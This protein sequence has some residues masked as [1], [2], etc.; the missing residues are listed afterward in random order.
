MATPKKTTAAAPAPAPKKSAL[1]V[2]LQPRWATALL[3]AVSIVLYA[4][5]FRHGYALDDSIVITENMFTQQGVKGWPGIFGKD[6]FFGYFKVEGKDR[7]VSGGRYRPLSLALFALEYQI[8]GNSPGAMHVANVLWYALTVAMCYYVFLL[9]FGAGE[10]ALRPSSAK[11]HYWALGAALIFAVHPLHT[12]AVANIKGRDEILSLLGSM[13]AL[14]LVLRA[15]VGRQPALLAGAFAA[16][17]LGLLSKENAITFLAVAPLALWLFAR[18]GVRQAIVY[19]LPLLGA[20]VVFL[21]IRGAVIG[22]DFGPESRELMNNPFLKYQAGRWVDFSAGE[23]LATI[24]YTLGKYLQLLVAPYPLTHDYYPKQVSIMRWTDWQA[25]LSLLVYLALIGYGLW[26]LW[27]RQ[28]PA[29]VIWFFLATLSIVSNLVFPIGT[30]MSER[31]LFMP[32]VAYGL[33]FAGLLAHFFFKDKKQLARPGALLG[34]TAAVALLYGGI[35]VGRNPV[36]KDN[37]TLF[38]TDVAASPNSA[39]LRNAAAGELSNY[40]LKLPDR[41]ANRQPLLEAIGHAKEAIRIHPT[42]LNAYLIL[43]NCYNYAQE[44][45]Q[46]IA[47]YKAALALD[48]AYEQADVNMALTYRDAGRYYGEQKGDLARSL[49]YL[50]EAYRQNPNDYETLR[51]LGVANGVGGRHDKAIEYFSDALKLEPNNAFAWFDL[52]TAYM[53]TGQAEEG[54]R[55]LAKAKELDPQIETKRQ[56]KR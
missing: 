32:S 3:I 34:A 24:T 8:F 40:W 50:E 1:P 12:E 33:A 49:T 5:T 44:Y 27:R 25:A 35:T 54:Q 28:W 7:L 53:I 11:A 55:H 52:G 6:T 51:L 23:R 46:A 16:F 48:P 41:D 13:G 15:Y 42:Y 36:W 39:K 9:L 37:Y 19:T 22:W 4:N 20:A 38:T 30:N 26:A 47:T 43:G 10:G 29:F 56:Q 14:A 31:F 21:L 45:D 17:L 2:W 18:A